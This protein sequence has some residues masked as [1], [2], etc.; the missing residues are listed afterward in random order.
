M[1][2]YGGSDVFFPSRDHFFLPEFGSDEKNNADADKRM[3]YPFPHFCVADPGYFDTAPDPDPRIRFVEK[4]STFYTFFSSD[5]PKN[6]CYVI[7]G[8]YNFLMLL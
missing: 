6:Y 8:I 4:M 1:Q 5:K 2:G 3:L 7:L